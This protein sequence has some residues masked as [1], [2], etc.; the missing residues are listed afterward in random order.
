MCY[1]FESKWGVVRERTSKFFS[2][3]GNVTSIQLEN[4]NY[5]V[6]H[7]MRNPTKEYEPNYFNAFSMALELVGLDPKYIFRLRE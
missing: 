6:K 2:F 1:N 5:Y 3:D 7:G 4:N